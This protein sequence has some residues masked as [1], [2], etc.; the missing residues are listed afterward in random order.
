MLN[1]KKKLMFNYNEIINLNFK[2]DVRNRYNWI[3]V[4]KEANINK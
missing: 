1:I 3:V 2:F 4:L